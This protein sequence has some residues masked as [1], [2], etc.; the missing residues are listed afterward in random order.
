ML[1]DFVVK[2][3]NVFLRVFV[4]FFIQRLL[5]KDA[6]IPF[7]GFTK[8]SSIL[9]RVVWAGD[10]KTG[11]G[12]KIELREQKL[13]RSPHVKLTGNPAVKI[14][15]QNQTYFPVIKADMKGFLAK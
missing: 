7:L 13:W 11:L 12:I 8:K 14:I 9:T 15:K 2:P 4:S 1:L 10:S 5:V 3:K 6:E